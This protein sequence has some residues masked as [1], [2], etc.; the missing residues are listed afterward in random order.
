[1][2]EF[3]GEQQNADT[4]LMW[5]YLEQEQYDYQR[6]M[7]GDIRY[8][9]VLHKAN[10][11]IILDIGVKLDAV[12]PSSDLDKLTPEEIAEVHVGDSIPVY[13]LSPEDPE[14]RIVVSINMAKSQEDWEEAEKYVASG[15]I[16]SGE[17]AGYNKGGL[18]V[19]FGR[20]RGFI[21]ASQVA[22]LT[23][24]AS[25][26]DGNGRVDQL[27]EMVGREI[28]AKVIEVDSKRRRLILSERS[29]MR[30]WRAE[31]KSRLMDELQ[32]GD[33]R[34]GVVT[35][36]LNFGAFVDLGGADGLVHVSELVWHRVKHPK[37]VL[38]IGD[39]VEVYV[40]S[41]DR[42]DE[43][44]ALSMKRLQPDPW[45]Q[46]TTKYSVGDVVEGEVTNLADFGAFAR[47]EAGVEGLIHISELTDEKIEHPREVVHR[48]QRIPVRIISIDTD[49]Q[50]IGLSYKRAPQETT[51]VEEFDD[52]EEDAAMSDEQ[53]TFEAAHDDQPMVEASATDDNEPTE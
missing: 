32:V 2:K 15:D 33:V 11:E 53:P 51:L 50:R 36:L 28:K 30:E 39:A 37:D 4:A 26:P 48:G 22:G 19:P 5:E 24:P 35:N 17:V 29:A 45:T 21:P 49:R 27:A 38:S 31:N 8:G 6:P 9:T 1:M 34:K 46:V 44:I 52:E 16:F 10:H 41:V 12:I 43:R 47:I 7:R 23:G 20:L 40:L 25:G 42:E 14:G 13:I 3:V 18:I